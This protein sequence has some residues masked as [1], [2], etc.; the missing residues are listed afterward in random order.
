G[1]R[2][3]S[4]DLWRGF[5]VKEKRRF[6]RFLRSY[7][8]SHRHRSPRQSM[9]VIEALM[10]RG[11]LTV[12]KGRVRSCISGESYRI[13]LD[14]EQEPLGS[15]DLCFDCTGLWSNLRSSGDPLI[16]S[17]VSQNLAA[18]DELDL[19]LR[20]D[21]RGQLING[22]NR[23][24][25]GLFTLGSLRRGELWETTA[26]REIRQQASCIAKAIVERTR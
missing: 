5:G 2:P 23:L 6:S 7:W 16:T 11:R 10:N 19:G 3:Y 15:F 17:L 20:A 26:V 14:S 22:S 24:V 8:D 9:A 21:A 12:R 1:L 18:L 13:T 4:H 25:P